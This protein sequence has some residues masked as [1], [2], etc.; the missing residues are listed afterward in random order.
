[1]KLYLDR[2]LPIIEQS[3]VYHTHGVDLQSKEAIASASSS[4]TQLV[5][6]LA[7]RVLEITAQ[8]DITARVLRGD[9]ARPTSLPL[10]ED[11]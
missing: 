4:L 10:P 8:R 1:V 3:H 9:A 7:P 6:H 5:E 11:S 2:V